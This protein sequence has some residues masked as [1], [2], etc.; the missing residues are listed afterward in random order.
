MTSNTLAFSDMNFNTTTKSF[1][2]TPTF[3]KKFASEGFDAFYVFTVKSAYALSTYSRIYLEF[4]YG[5][6]P[7][8]NNEGYAECYIRPASQS[9]LVQT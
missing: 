7:Q 2:T 5:V 8:L 4:P 3:A 1:A 9:L 6:S